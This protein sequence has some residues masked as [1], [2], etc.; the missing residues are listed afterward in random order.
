[1][2]KVGLLALTVVC[3]NSGGKGEVCADPSSYVLNG[4]VSTAQLGGGCDESLTGVGVGK[5][6]KTGADCTPSCC[7]CPGASG[8]NV[9]VGYCTGGICATAEEACC[10]FVHQESQ[11]DGGALC[12]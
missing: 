1:M 5:P 7:A 4:S 9:S 2:W 11:P 8:T 12:P 6:C 10:T 3:C